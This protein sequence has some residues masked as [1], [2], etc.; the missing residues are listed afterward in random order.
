MF[1]N[2]V[3]GEFLFLKTLDAEREKT[4]LISKYAN[5]NTQ[6]D[7]QCL[8]LKEKTYSIYLPGTIPKYMFLIK[9]LLD[10]DVHCVAE[11]F[12][13]MLVDGLELGI[14]PKY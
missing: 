7:I 8:Q 5:S 3:L 13:L 2:I 6:F 10:W 4:F 12:I 14:V 11:C 1:G 9:K